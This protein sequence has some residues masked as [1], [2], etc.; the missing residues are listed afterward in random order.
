MRGVTGAAVRVM[1]GRADLDVALAKADSDF[2]M[3]AFPAWFASDV[4]DG[5]LDALQVGGGEVG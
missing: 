5:A 1:R 3:L 2:G 4:A